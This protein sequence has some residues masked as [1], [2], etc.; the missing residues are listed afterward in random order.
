MR[1]SIPITKPYFD[2][3]ELQKV[4]ECLESGWVTQGPMVQK[5]EKLF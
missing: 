3:K 1:K 2:E 5:F 4:K